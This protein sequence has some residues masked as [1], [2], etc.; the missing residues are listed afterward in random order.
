MS[1]VP[2]GMSAVLRFTC[3][4]LVSRQLYVLAMGSFPVRLYDKLDQRYPLERGRKWN[5]QAFLPTCL[6]FPTEQNFPVFLI[7]IVWP[8]Q[9]PPKM[10][11]PTP[12]HVASQA[13]T[14]APGGARDSQPVASSPRRWLRLS[15]Q[16]RISEVEES[17]NIQDST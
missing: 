4:Q 2:M 15:Q 14:E 17:T 11:H 16:L 8:H 6:L 3:R 5:L 1:L 10:S 9:Q 7:H 13:T 12:Y